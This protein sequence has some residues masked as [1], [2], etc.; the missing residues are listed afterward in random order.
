L[1]DRQ[2][3]LKAV[4]LASVFAKSEANVI[5]LE[6]KEGKI[7]LSSEARQLGGQETEIEAS[8]GQ[9][10]ITIAFN[11]KYLIDALSAANTE[12]IRIEF[13]GN[14]SAAL[15]KPEGTEGLEYVI[16]PIRLS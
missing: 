3:L 13:S 16:M 11:A 15:L 6:T 9:N 4:K 2:D 14:L 5:K 12:K 7:K 10:P 1:K 8:T